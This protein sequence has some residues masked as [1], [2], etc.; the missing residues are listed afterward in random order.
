MVWPELVAVALRTAVWHFGKS[1]QPIST[2]SSL[3]AG[4]EQ[5]HLRSL[6]IADSQRA[7][8]LVWVEALARR[9]GPAFEHGLTIAAD[10]CV[11]A[12]LGHAAKR[13]ET[14]AGRRPALIASCLYLLNPLLIL[15]NTATGVEHVLNAVLGL[16]LMSCYKGGPRI[17]SLG[18]SLALFLDPE[19]GLLIFLTLALGMGLHTRGVLHYA[20]WV[21][22]WSG[23]FSLWTHQFASNWLMSLHTDWHLEPRHGLHWNLFTQV[24]SPF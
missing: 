1:P 23:L 11:A 6:G 12:C 18:V 9:R 24:L 17:A 19:R 4:A 14:D 21:V 5:V 10:L 16:I 20:L 2:V 3:R 13:V 7:P 15:W 22:L 8:L